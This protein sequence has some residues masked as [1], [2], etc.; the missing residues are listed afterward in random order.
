MVEAKAERIAERVWER[1]YIAG[2]TPA[3]AARH[4]TIICRNSMSPQERIRTAVRR[5]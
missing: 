5:K 1:L 4:A 2:K 3:E